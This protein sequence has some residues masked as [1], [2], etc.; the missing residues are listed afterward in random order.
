M[1]GDW[2]CEHLEE[3]FYRII[4]SK[5][6]EKTKKDWNMLWKL[7]LGKITNQQTLKRSKNV[8]DEHYNIIEIDMYKAMLGRT[9]SYTCGYWKN[10]DTLDE[11]QDAKHKLI[12]K[13]LHLKS[14][15]RVLEIGSGFGIL[16]NYMAD[17]YGCEVTGINISEVHHKYAS[18][19]ASNNVDFQLVDYRGFK[20]KEKF[21]KIVS[22]G[23][24]EAVGTKNYKIFFN[25]VHSLLKEGGLFLLH[26]IGTH[27]GESRGDP[28]ITKYIFPGG[29]LP[30]L[31]EII[32]V[33]D[34]LFIMEDWHNFGYYYYPTLMAWF[35]QF[36]G[37]WTESGRDINEPYYRMWKYYLLMC[38][39]G[40][41]ARDNS[42][43]QIVFSKGGHP[44]GYISIR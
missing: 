13:K 27:A 44:N 7:F 16:C 28:W 32:N 29:V 21:D 26:T 31:S 39:G 35:K 19:H 5:V 9:F 23:M 6:K 36:H 43:W 12:C 30:R 40:F 20:P 25:I 1:Q 10:V 24:I 11:A 37:Y 4:K 34:R 3:F 17:N 18:E 38:A 15:E 22:V 8:I 33:S 2:D 42:L 41:K 14:G